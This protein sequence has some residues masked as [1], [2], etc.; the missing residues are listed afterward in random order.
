M[1]YAIV[2]FML[3]GISFFIRTVVTLSKQ[4]KFIFSRIVIHLIQIQLSN[5]LNILLT[6]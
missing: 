1:T 2:V 5:A 6:G 4:A 3:I